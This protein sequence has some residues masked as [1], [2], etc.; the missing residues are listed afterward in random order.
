MLL[1]GLAKSQSKADVLKSPT[2]ETPPII[3][4]PEIKKSETELHWEELVNGCTR[5]LALCDL[6]FTDLHSD[7]EQSILGPANLAGGIPPP[8]PPCGVPPPIPAPAVPSLLNPSA[9]SRLTSPVCKNKKTVKLFW[10]VCMYNVFI[11]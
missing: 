4:P 8:P 10:K 11:S 5:S 1:S 9:P 2:S 7:D 3:K 6:D